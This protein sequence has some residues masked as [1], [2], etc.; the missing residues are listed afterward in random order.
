MLFGAVG[1]ATFAGHDHPVQIPGKAHNAVTLLD[2][3][4]MTQQGRAKTAIGC[5]A[6][7]S[8]LGSTIGIFILIALIPL[9]RQAAIAL[10]PPE[11]LMLAIWGLTMLA[12]MTGNS[13]LKAWRSWHRTGMAMIGYDPRTVG[14]LWRSICALGSAGAGFPQAITIAVLDLIISG[15]ETLTDPRRGAWRQ[16]HQCAVGVPALWPVSAQLFHWHRDRCHPGIGSTVAG[17]IAQPCQPDRRKHSRFGHGDIRKCSR[18]R[19]RWMPRTGRVDPDPAL[20]YPVVP[21][22]QCCSAH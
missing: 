15:R 21:A 11:Y 19:P 4:P 7:S 20:G 14:S 16:C 2:G 10:G 12:A 22:P 17:F 6:A 9:M 18:Q 13:L 5:A 8:A 3:Y 1:G